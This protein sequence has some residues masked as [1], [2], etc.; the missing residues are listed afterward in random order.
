MSISI[1]IPTI[2]SPP[3]EIIKESLSSGKN[4][5]PEIWTQI[6]VV[7][8]SNDSSYAKF[9]QEEMQSDPRVEI[10]HIEEKLN[11]AQCW[12]IGL[13]K[14][15]E[16]HTLFLHDDDVLI[17]ENLPLSKLKNIKSFINFG[18]DVFGAENWTYTPKIYG[19][20]GICTNTPKLVSTIFKTSALR[21]IGGWDENSGYFLDFLAFLKL[22]QRYG[23]DSSTE[24]L[25]KYRLHPSNASAKERRNEAYGDRLPYVL[26]EIF[27]VV[28]GEDMRREV[29]HAM[30]T[31]AYPNDS[32]KKKFFSAVAKSIGIQ[33][34]LK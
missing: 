30:L 13:G 9:L 10:F 16:E 34:W 19:I 11:M 21:D 31:F 5:P 20:Q 14:V 22:H 32:T 7:N 23:S 26:G 25:G 1:V 17:S 24:T 27:S 18:F 4:S 33:S 29:L 15:K 3:L 12:N 6:I 2:G 28:K 8:N